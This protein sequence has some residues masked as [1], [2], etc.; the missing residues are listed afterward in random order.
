MAEHVADEKLRHSLGADVLPA[1]DEERRLGAVVVGDG[2]DGVVVLRLWEFGD[3]VH[4]NHLEGEGPCRWEDRAQRCFGRVSVDLVSLTLC[5][6]SDI[7]YDILSKSRPPMGSLHQ[8]CGTIDSWMTISWKVVSVVN[9]L[10]KVRG[11]SGDYQ[12][13]ILPPFSVNE[14]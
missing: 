3:E 8:F 13:S 12:S 2:E 9:E 14:L 7:L 10:L 1:G 11:L 5:T 6:S 4:R